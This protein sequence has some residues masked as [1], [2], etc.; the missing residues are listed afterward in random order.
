[1]KKIFNEKYNN[2]IITS[3]IIVVAV[4]IAVFTGKE[5]YEFRHYNQEFIIGD[6]VT[7]I[8]KFSDYNPL[9]AGTVGDADIFVIE[10][11]KPGPSLL[12]LGGTHPN[13]PSGQ[14][15]SVLFLENLHVEEGTV[16]LITEANRS[17]FSATNPQEGSPMFY[18]IETLTGKRTFKYG[19][20]ATNFIDQWPN[21]DIYVHPDSGQKLSNQDTRNLNRSYPGRIDGY[22]TQRVA[23]AITQLIIQNNIT[24]TIDLHEASPEYLTNNAIVAHPGAAMSVASHA[25]L[26]LELRGIAIKIESSPENLHGLTH[27][28]L[29]VYTDTLAFL[30]ETSNASQ[31]KIHG[32]F[33]EE[34]IITGQDK[35]YEKAQTLGLLYAAP[36]DLSERVARHTAS[37]MQIIESYNSI[38]NPGNLEGASLLISNMPS[39]EDIIANGV[40]TYLK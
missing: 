10:G 39:Y 32:K 23:Y 28:E 3:L 12:V 38:Y 5:Y 6:N 15:T 14:L 9:L 4:I 36:T 20:R 26:F 7:R 40:G 13:E 1:M 17:A 18:E 24:M 27:R 34:L 22:Y 29:G 19:S 37:I 8:E 30:C 33:T 31:G 35:F 21:P 2:I 16:Y 11:A 25:Y